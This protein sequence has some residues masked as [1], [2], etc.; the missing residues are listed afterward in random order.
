MAKKLSD[1]F[2]SS[3]RRAAR[4][5]RRMLKQMTTPVRKARKSAAR[6][7]ST[8]TASAQT[9]S[10]KTSAAKGSWQNFVHNTAPSR[11]EL[12]GRLAYSLY[13]PKDH[14]LP[15]LPLVIML[16]GCQ[17]TATDFAAGTRMNALA[18][19]KG[20][21]VAYPQQ[22]KRVQAMRCWRWFQPDAGH[23]LAE[24]D[25]IADLAGT[26]VRRFGLDADRVYI[27][28]LSAGAGMAALAILRHPN[29]FAAA[30]LHSGAVVGAARNATAGL[31]VMRKASDEE[32]VKLVAPLLNPLQP[33]L[34]R[35]VMIIH[36]QR[37]HVVAPRNAGQ[38]A[39]QFSGLTGGRTQKRSVLAQGTHREYIRQD[40]LKGKQTVVRLCLLKEV[41]HAWGGGDERFKFHT[42]K[43]PNASVLIWQFFAMQARY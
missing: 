7:T 15:G 31:Q 16:H 28:G 36:G 4:A 24:A 32:P 41:G 40:F 43:G 6:K 22:A 20:F 33:F 39:E 11:S 21:V 30:A 34:A 13:R 14:P 37:D 12:L 38:L 3:V 23:G 1:L 35:P 27:A 25:A 9:T 10:A 26:L 17:Q 19:K 5:Q 29:I 2:F 42:K 8:K 18:D